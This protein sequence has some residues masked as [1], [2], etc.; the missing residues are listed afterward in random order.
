MDPVE[1][2]ELKHRI[3]CMKKNKAGRR[4]GVTADLLQVLEDPILM[5]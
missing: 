3:K 2:P 5:N 4:S 1:L